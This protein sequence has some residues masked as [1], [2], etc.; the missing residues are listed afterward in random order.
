RFSSDVTLTGSYVSQGADN[1]FVRSLNCGSNSTITAG[2]GDRFFITGTFSSA[3]SNG[4]P[5]PGLFNVG[6]AEVHF[7]GGSQ[8]YVISGNGSSFPVVT[9]DAGDH[10]K[11]SGNCSQTDFVVSGTLAAQVS[12]TASVHDISGPGAVVINGSSSLTLSLGST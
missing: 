4:N 10:L 2:A 12:A 11:I 6:A 7:T 5:P 8:S 9:V 1:Y 3:G